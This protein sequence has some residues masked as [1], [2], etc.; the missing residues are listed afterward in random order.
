MAIGD[1]YVTG[2]QVADRLGQEYDP[3]IHDPLAEASSAAVE[4]FTHRQ[5]NRADEISPRR[6]RALDS[7]R[8]PV[9]D[10]WSTDGLVV[11]VNG[12]TWPDGSVDPRPWDGIVDGQPGW[13]FFDLFTVRRVWPWSRRAN[14]TISAKWGWSQVPAAIVAATLD[15]A[16]DFVEAGASGPV[17]SQSIDGYSVS[18]ATSVMLARSDIADFGP[19][20]KAAPY[21]RLRFGVA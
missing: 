4:L 14:V 12:S 17:R 16:V 3:A 20:A 15:V 21:R 6:F 7:E 10:F 5:F 11:V 13:P 8:L 19:F 18:Y 1:P 9:D 2:V